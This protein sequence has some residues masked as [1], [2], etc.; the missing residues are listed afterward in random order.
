MRKSGIAIALAVVMLSCSPAYADSGTPIMFAGLFHLCLANIA[1][2][3]VEALLLRWL[4][5]VSL[6]RTWKVMLVANFFSTL[7]GLL[8]FPLLHYHIRPW[9][10]G[11]EPLYRITR[12]IPIMIGLSY[13]GTILLEWPFVALAMKGLPKRLS[14]SLV[15]SVAAQTTSYVLLIPFYYAAS[16]V[17]PGVTL[18][19]QL[20]PQTSN[21]VTIW[22]SDPSD[23]CLYSIGVNGNNRQRIMPL[24]LPNGQIS[25][26]VELTLVKEQETN[27]WDLFFGDKLLMKELAVGL[28]DPDSI[29]SGQRFRRDNRSSFGST[30][31]R[32]ANYL[33]DQADQHKWK[34]WG[35]W[36]YGLR[37]NHNRTGVDI[38]FEGPWFVDYVTVVPGDRVVF[39]F[40]NQIVLLRMD[41]FQMGLITFGTQP[42]AL[43]NCYVNHRAQPATA[44]SML[45][46]QDP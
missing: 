25:A 42:I 4:F 3:F 41:T 40:A 7:V 6:R 43:P 16:S 12:M 18:D 24:P 30:P 11:D 29:R 26:F 35:D 14:K 44:Q 45:A 33:A 5:K 8:V 39:G 31:H 19:R 23:R 10:V 38:P 46:S 13:L 21:D 36:W 20:V 15:G 22:Y 9:I 32:P 34:V 27:K 37:V 17:L 2:A 1:I 28:P